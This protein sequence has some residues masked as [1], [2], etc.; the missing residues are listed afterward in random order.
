M[1]TQVAT[2]GA[3]P[4]V[5]RVPARTCARPTTEQPASAPR[6]APDRSVAAATV[7]VAWG[8]V[9]SCALAM[10][11]LDGFVVVAL[12]GVAGSIERTDHLFVSWVRETLLVLPVYVA[13]LL[14]A[15]MLISRRPA[16]GRPYRH[17]TVT[18]L[19]VIAAAGTL[20]AMGWATASSA[21]DLRLQRHEFL[22]MPAMQT[23]CTGACAERMQRAAFTL[24]ERTLGLAA[25]TFLVGNLVMVL[26]VYALR[27]G[28]VLPAT[29]PSSSPRTPRPGTT[30]GPLARRRW[31]KVVRSDRRADLVAVMAVSMLCA[32][33][34]HLAVVPEHL[35]E[36]P[37]AAVFFLLLSLAELGAGALVLVRRSRLVV[38]AA[39]LLAV[40]PLAL[41]TL[42]RTRGLPFGPEPGAAEAVGFADVAACTLELVTL[43]ACLFLL[44]MGRAP[45]GRAVGPYAAA[46]GLTSLL[47]VTTLGLGGSA[48]PGVHAFGVA[49][50]GGGSDQTSI[51][52]HRLPGS[53]VPPPQLDP[54]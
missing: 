41:W 10:G 38:V 43:A 47:A 4:V 6:G 53:L 23:A 52:T 50:H 33:P 2:R 20:V 9:V 28:V 29:H 32:A 27:G 14:V 54:G 8:L 11:F 3:G 44:R 36:W 46:L 37:L 17:P 31:W 1:S 15:V 12:R 22:D 24:Q 13:A 5:G 35:A 19:G 40:L 51:P 30:G 26:W 25:V 18:M 21:Y 7:H 48:L 34:I 16:R 49:G 42:S 45:G 39:G